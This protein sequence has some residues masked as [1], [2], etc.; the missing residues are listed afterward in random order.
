MKKIFIFVLL[1]ASFSFAMAQVGGLSASKLGAYS[2]GTVPANN[3]EFEPSFGFASSTKYFD[4]KGN[5]SGLFHS[6]DS[7]QRFSSMGLRF[8]YGVIKDLEVGISLSADM[9]DINWGMKYKLKMTGNTQIAFFAGYE[10]V[11]GNMIYVKRNLVHEATSSVGGGLIISHVFSDKL[12]MDINGQYH[13]HFHSTLNGHD[14]GYM[15]T[16]DIG[17]YLLK[18]INFIGELVYSLNINN[19]SVEN[20][21]QLFTFNPGIAI[22]RSKHFILVLNTPIDL[23][24]KNEYQTT[25]FGMALTILLD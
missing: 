10:S 16:T 11:M 13:K 8:T 22:E 1:I 23:W 12:S 3:I 14:Q 7:I 20:N 18:N 2:A 19:T 5:R 6:D 17:Y 15:L 25:G 9:S 24:G 21:S 4:K